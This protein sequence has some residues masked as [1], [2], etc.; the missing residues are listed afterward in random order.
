MHTHGRNSFLS[1]GTCWVAAG[2]ASGAGRTQQLHSRAV[3]PASVADHIAPQAVAHHNPALVYSHL[4]HIQL[5]VVDVVVVE[6]KLL[7]VLARSAS[8]AVCTFAP[9]HTVQLDRKAECNRKVAVV[10]VVVG[11]TAVPVLPH[12][13]KAR[14][15]QDADRMWSALWMIEQ[16]SPM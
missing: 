8:V 10:V 12:R 13:S 15:R 6:C 11:H 14:W 3:G 5:A 16:C 9:A 1:S 4:A 2:P 7:A